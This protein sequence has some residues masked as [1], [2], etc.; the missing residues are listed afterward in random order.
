[1]KKKPKEI[2]QNKVESREGTQKK[3][4]VWEKAKGS[5]KRKKDLTRQKEGKSKLMREERTERKQCNKNKKNIR[6]PSEEK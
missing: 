3:S 2:E 4:T 6:N 1:M 5:E